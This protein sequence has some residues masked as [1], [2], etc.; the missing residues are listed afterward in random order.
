MYSSDHPEVAGGCSLGTLPSLASKTLPRCLWALDK[1]QHY[2]LVAK[3]GSASRDGA[4]SSPGE[5]GKLGA[6]ANPIAGLDQTPG[7]TQGTPSANPGRKEGRMEGRK[8][9]EGNETQG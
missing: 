5:S 9:K 6:E 8:K 2:H 4:G 7:L 1:E 3:A